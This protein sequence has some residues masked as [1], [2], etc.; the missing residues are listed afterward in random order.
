MPLNAPDIIEEKQR[1]RGHKRKRVEGNRNFILTY[2]LEK[3]HP[4]PL[5]DSCLIMCP[6]KNNF[7]HESH[8]SFI[9]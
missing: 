9:L 3:R 2:L 8:P 5:L 1:K 6:Q 7:V 4:L